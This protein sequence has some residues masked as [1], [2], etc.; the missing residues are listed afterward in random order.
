[1]SRDNLL[2]RIVPVLLSS[3]NDLSRQL[4]YQNFQG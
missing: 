3:A 2:D 1:M 4:G